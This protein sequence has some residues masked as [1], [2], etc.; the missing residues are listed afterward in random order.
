MPSRTPVFYFQTTLKSCAQADVP[1]EFFVLVSV[2]DVEGERGDG[3]ELAHA[4]T[5]TVFHAHAFEVACGIADIVEDGAGYAF[6]NRELVFE[7][8]DQ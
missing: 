2:G 7:A 3:A 1:T 6:G 8:A 4:E 5:G